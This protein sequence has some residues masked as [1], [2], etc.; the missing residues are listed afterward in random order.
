MKR[1]C[2]LVCLFALAACGKADNDPGPGGI[3][4]GEAKALDQAAKML[5]ARRPPAEALEPSTAQWP[6]GDPSEAAERP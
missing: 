6:Q 2:L 4:V 3:T 5:D 1:A